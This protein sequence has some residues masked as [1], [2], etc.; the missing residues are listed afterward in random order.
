MD[1]EHIK[2]IF[3]M[4]IFGVLGGIYISSGKIVLIFLGVICIS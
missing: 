3:W 4:T 2:A 1:W